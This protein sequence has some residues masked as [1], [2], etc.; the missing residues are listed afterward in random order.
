MKNIVIK[1]KTAYV[2]SFAMEVYLPADYSDKAYRG[3]NYYEVAGTEVRY[4]GV[5][6]MRFFDSEKEMT[7]I[8][9]KTEELLSSLKYTPQSLGV[10]SSSLIENL[11]RILRFFKSAKAEIIGYNIV[12]RITSRGINFFK[13]LDKIIVF[14]DTNIHI[15]F[16]SPYYDFIM[17]IIDNRNPCNDNLIMKDIITFAD[18]TPLK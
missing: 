6:N 8:V 4:F 12:Y 17:K 9:D 18:G 14:N 5:G 10:E 15:D 13:L 11:F 3:L 1:D 2:D 7:N 16:E